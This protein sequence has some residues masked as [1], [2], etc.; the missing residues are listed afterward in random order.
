MEPFPSLSLGLTLTYNL[1]ATSAC[2]PVEFWCL[3]IILME[4][5]LAHEYFD[6]SYGRD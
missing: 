3:L 6:A 2:L 4:P 5:K 1:Y